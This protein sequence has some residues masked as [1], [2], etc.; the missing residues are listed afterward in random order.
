MGE[1]YRARDTRLDRDV[2]IKVL[3]SSL[4]ADPEARARFEREARAVSQLNHPHI[5][6]LYDV[7]QSNDV[8][9]L[10]MEY[11]DGESLAARLARGPL[12]PDEALDYAVQIADALDK[13]HRHGIVHRD[14]KPAN[15]MLTRGGAARTLAI[16]SRTG[17]SIAKL[18][19]F[20]LAKLAPPPTIGSKETV[21]AQ[22]A[23]TSPP[24]A[25]NPATAE[26]TIL[27]TF[28]YMAPEQ[29]EGGDIDARADIWAFGCVLYE[30]LT[31]R[32]AFEGKTQ[33][34]V[35]ASILG[36]DPTP[37]AELQPLAPPALG[38]VIRICLAKDP[39]ARFQSSY[40]LLLQ[41]Q[42]IAEGGSAAGL[43]APTI[44][45]RKR[46]ERIWWVAAAAATLAVGAAG[47]WML[48]PAP[49]ITNVSERFSYALP[50]GQNFSRTGRRYLAI[51]P[52]GTRVAFI[53]NRQI[54]LREMHQLE[55]HPI[56]GTNEDPLNL[57]FSPDGQWIAYFV[58]LNTGTQT[59]S[60]N[61][62]L[63]KIQVTGGTPV[64]LCTTGWP[65]GA[66]W[67]DHTIVFGQNS[68]QVH[69]IQV[70]P[71]TAGTPATLVT[72]GKDEQATQPRL[73]TDGKLVLFTVRTGTT[74]T[75][76][77]A[78]LVLQAPG[79]STRTV[80][81]K[82]A[83]DGQLIADRLVYYREG[84][85]FGVGID[86]GARATRGGPVPIIEGVQS[87]TAGAGA[88]VLS[89]ADNGTLVFVPGGGELGTEP[90]QLVWVDRAGKEEKIPA[91]ERPY[92][93]PRLSPDGTRIVVV[94]D[95]GA[96][97]SL[98]TWDL[99]RSVLT[100]LSPSGNQADD[101]PL[102]TLDGRSVVYRSTKPDGTVTIMR[103]DAS[104][105]AAP[106]SLLELGKFDRGLQGLLDS[107]TP[108]GWLILRLGERLDVVAL[109]L[110]GQDKRLRKLVAEPTFEYD[111][112]V[113][114]DGRWLAYVMGDVPG[115]GQIFVR[116]YPNVAANR[117]QLSPTT[118][119]DI[120]WARSGREIF[121]L[122]DAGRMMSVTVQP[123]P[124]FGRAVDLF[125]NRPYIAM[126]Q[127]GIDYDTT[128]EGRFLMINRRP[129]ESDG[130]G[131]LAQ[132]LTVVTHW[133]DELRARVK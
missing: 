119:G 29:V 23:G 115:R 114:P 36:R 106:E 104:G 52:D 48:K 94:D 76:D 87:T 66:S 125:D 102:W 74:G 78:D 53:A 27:G 68:D 41:L 100:R 110:Q 55:S 12:P 40:D 14:L 112:K 75:W 39:N 28:Q 15:V 70:V 32:R 124:I 46:R 26:G 83:T 56:V 19:D 82:G 17:P 73:V 57:V 24:R 21:L 120:V 91:P 18:L 126:I 101:S 54:H 35:I 90:R 71:D 127:P 79:A 95:P 60:N 44:E 49:A 98:F 8:E 133:T 113:S 37:V 9:F 38:R 6:A 69:G 65:F 85:V 116:P 131:A 77:G 111:G 5:C 121:F 132:V 10:V 34:S 62:T 59:S 81:V 130:A 11:L 20:G 67:Q 31:G 122:S 108:D 25:A 80:L 22:N 93:H 42:W 1:V 105:A 33:A 61:F 103:I 7:G 72:V 45:R 117:W 47:A 88:A 118:A 2:A 96:S 99:A 13:A 50:T 107:I 129:Q 58:P 123:G 128:P 89:V 3:P 4:A 84:T 64:P 51:S 16:S 92:R 30:M 43:P 97:S 86:V 109:P 63:K